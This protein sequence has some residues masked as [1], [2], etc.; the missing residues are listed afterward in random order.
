MKPSIVY[1][2][3]IDQRS[4]RLNNLYSYGV[5]PFGAQPYFRLHVRSFAAD[6]STKIN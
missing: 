5:T 4:E 3:R 1:A 6:S 2:G